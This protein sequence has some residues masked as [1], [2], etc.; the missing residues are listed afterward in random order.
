MS[1]DGNYVLCKTNRGNWIGTHLTALSAYL[2]LPWH[3]LLEWKVGMQN[4][5]IKIPTIIPM[6][7]DLFFLEKRI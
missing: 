5:N 4:P 1:A 3:R 6:K 7:K 2:S